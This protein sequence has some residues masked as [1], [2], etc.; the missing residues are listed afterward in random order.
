M[1][2]KQQ[3]TIKIT[4]KNITKVLNRP[5]TKRILECFNDQPKTA[6]EIANSIS[7][8]KDKIYYHLKKL[9]A[10]N[11]LFVASIEKVKGIEQK[12]FLPT[13]KQFDTSSKSDP[14]ENIS[15][16]IEAKSL[17]LN[18][19]KS[20][21]FLSYGANLWLKNAAEFKLSETSKNILN[22]EYKWLTK[23]VD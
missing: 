4:D 23:E 6:G 10:N 17:S 9:L 21:N 8:P 7:F 11:I 22:K 1:V 20:L 5:F 16:F 3:D 13:A 15:N 12:Y 14:K 18:D 2:N 19:E